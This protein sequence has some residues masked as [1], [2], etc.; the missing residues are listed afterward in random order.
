MSSVADQTLLVAYTPPLTLPP[1]THSTGRDTQTH[2]LT[3]IF[4]LDYKTRD[5]TERA[6][7]YKRSDWRRRLPGYTSLFVSNLLALE[8]SRRWKKDNKK[9]SL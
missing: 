6:S 4:R 9:T 8:T 7:G 5:V 3:Q 2:I 1:H